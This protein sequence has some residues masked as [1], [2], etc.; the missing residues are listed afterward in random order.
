MQQPFAL[1]L[2]KGSAFNEVWKSENVGVGKICFKKNDGQSP[3]LFLL[4]T[5][6]NLQA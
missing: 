6:Q 4:L 5:N 2:R 1:Q 3:E